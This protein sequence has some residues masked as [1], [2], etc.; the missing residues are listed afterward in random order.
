MPGVSIFSPPGASP[1]IV[2]SD[3]NHEV[4]GFTFELMG[5]SGQF[6]KRFGFSDSRGGVVSAPT[7]RPG[8]Q[9]VV[10]TSNGRLLFPR[11]GDPLPAITGLAPV[12]STPTVLPDGRLLVVDHAAPEASLVV[13]RGDE[14]LSRTKLPSAVFSAAASNSHVYVATESSLL[15]FD[16]AKMQQVQKF[17]W[18]GGGY[19]PPSIGPQGH[20]YATVKNILLVFPPPSATTQ[21]RIPP[22]PPGTSRGTVRDHRAPAPR[23]HR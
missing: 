4:V 23:D 12:F 1:V 2:V 13:I 7:H 3:I 8:G 6:T 9:A 22:P 18:V 19:W 15:T 17:D 20:V 11:L 21:P 5:S 14:V 16:T 10:A